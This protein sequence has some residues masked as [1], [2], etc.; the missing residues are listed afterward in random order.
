MKFSTTILSV[1]LAC[2]FLLAFSSAFAQ[3]RE[4]P[5]AL[6]GSFA[7]MFPDAQNLDWAVKDDGFECEFTVNGLESEVKYDL[8]G[9]ILVVERGLKE[10]ELPVEVAS[11]ISAHFPEL[12]FMEASEV[13]E[14]EV[15]VYE[16]DLEGNGV[17]T[18]LLF[19]ST[20]QL[21]HSE[22]ESLED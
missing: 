9:N 5:Q 20:G 17:E 14:G 11:Y 12:S 2:L 8:S 19:S 7:V 22:Q 18:E 10:D 6:K 1:S 16:V 21:L 3:P 13:V 15:T 4:V